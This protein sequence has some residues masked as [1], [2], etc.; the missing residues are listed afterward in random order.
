MI[1]K[2]KK[3]VFEL[4]GNQLTKKNIGSSWTPYRFKYT[5]S[6]VAKDKKLCSAVDTLEGRDA[7]QRDLSKLKR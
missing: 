2:I 4:A 3:A 5:L 6:K 1:I 7:I